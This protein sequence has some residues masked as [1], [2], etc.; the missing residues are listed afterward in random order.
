VFQTR[1]GQS[2]EDINLLPLPGIKPI[3]LDRP[4]RS[5]VTIPTELFRFHEAQE[6]Q[7][8]E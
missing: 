1:C 6:I 4:V 7:I 5:L 3:Y 2:G 8:R